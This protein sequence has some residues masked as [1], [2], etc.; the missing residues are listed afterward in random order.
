M[1]PHPKTGQIVDYALWVH[2]GHVHYPSGKWIPEQPF[3]QD[4]IN[5]HIYELYQIL[6]VSVNKSVNTVWTDSV[7]DPSEAAI[8]VP[9]SSFVGF[10]ES[11]GGSKRSAKQATEKLPDII[12]KEARSRMDTWRAKVLATA[13]ALCPVDYGILQA[14]IRWEKL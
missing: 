2:D 8:K 1:L 14:T 6:N 5:I 12:S 7:P 11:D 3:I 13:K 4:A 10:S 9:Q